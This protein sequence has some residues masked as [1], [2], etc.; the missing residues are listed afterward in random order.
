MIGYVFSVVRHTPNP[1][2]SLFIVLYVHFVFAL[3]FTLVVQRVIRVIEHAARLSNK[4]ILS[5]LNARTGDEE[6]KKDKRS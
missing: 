4:I 1:A 5:T 3:S 6:R 2:C